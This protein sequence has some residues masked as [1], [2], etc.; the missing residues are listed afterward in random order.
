MDGKN[1]ARRSPHHEEALAQLA[2]RYIRSHG[3]ATAHD[4]AWWTGLTLTEA[5]EAISYAEGLRQQV[6]VGES[7]YWSGAEGA[8]AAVSPEGRGAQRFGAF[9]GLS[10]DWQLQSD[11]E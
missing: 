9:I 3:P 1:Q 7:A 4:V 10:V 11:C 2:T 6:A 5:R 8:A